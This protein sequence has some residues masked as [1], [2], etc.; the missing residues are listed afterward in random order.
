M[1]VPTI[2]NFL[3]I[4][5]FSKNFF[6]IRK[7]YVLQ[8][9]TILLLSS[10]IYLCSITGFV[11]FS[12]IL[13]ISSYI[14]FVVVFFL[15]SFSYKLSIVMLGYFVIICSEFLS[16]WFSNTCFKNIVLD[17]TQTIIL[18]TATTQLFNYLIG[19][20]IIR[21]IQRKKKQ[22]FELI[23]I[24]FIA[25]TFFI[26]SIRDI[27]I[28]ITKNPYILFIFIVLILFDII[29]ISEIA[30]FT[31]RINAQKELDELKRKDLILKSKYDLLNQNYKTNIKFLHDS[32]HLYSQLN[33]LIDNNK[34]DQA[35][36][37]IDLTANKSAKDLY[38]FY[39]NSPVLSA[40]I[41]E[42]QDILQKNNIKV[43][44][45]IKN[46]ELDNI[47]LYEKTNLFSILFDCALISCLNSNSKFKSISIK[48]DKLRNQN[49][50]QV[51]FSATQDF[52]S[53]VT[54][55]NTMKII[56]T[57]YAKKS[58]IQFIS[59]TNMCSIILVL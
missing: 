34:I 32:L 20:F 27:T 7:N 11:I 28:T 21:I 33:H 9:I 22:N 23:S 8:S 59:S 58:D 47:S 16:V 37:L 51:S 35:K 45:T 26:I 44:T 39:T 57:Q 29:S 36:E 17:R 46:D 24:P 53:D 38:Q 14:L 42:H 3:F 52:L 41:L 48:T 31:Y 43:T 50:I 40:I 1:I 15:N 54:I 18:L 25:T 10:L 6:K 49:I 19:F 30:S 5:L 55:I 2:F 13:S 56:R 12:K 4:I